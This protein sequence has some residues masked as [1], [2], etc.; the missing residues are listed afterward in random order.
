MTQLRRLLDACLRVLEVADMFENDAY[1]MD[2][3]AL[4]GECENLIEDLNDK[5][6]I[7]MG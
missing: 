7:M 3:E 5:L 6:K 4:R 1:S 2:L